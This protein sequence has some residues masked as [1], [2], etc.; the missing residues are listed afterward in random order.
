[1]LR[2]VGPRLIRGKGIEMAKTQKRG[3]Q[4]NERALD[5]LREKI[6][7]KLGF[8]DE[9][10]AIAKEIGVPFRTVERWALGETWPPQNKLL[11][12]LAYISK[13]QPPDW[14]QLT[15]RKDYPSSPMANDDGPPPMLPARHVLDPQ[16]VSKAMEEWQI[17]KKFLHEVHGIP[18]GQIDNALNGL[19]VERVSA[20]RIA[21]VLTGSI[22][23]TSLKLPHA[24]SEG[25]PKLPDNDCVIEVIFRNPVVPDDPTGSKTAALVLRNLEDQELA[26]QPELAD[27]KKRS[28]HVFIRVTEDEARRIKSAFDHGLLDYL[29]IADVKIL[30]PRRW[31]WQHLGGILGLLGLLCATAAT[32]LHILRPGTV[33]V[34]LLAVAGLTTAISGV[35]IARKRKLGWRVPAVAAIMNAAILV[36]AFAAFLPPRKDDN[37]GPGPIIEKDKG[38]D[39]GKDGKKGND[40][41]K[42]EAKDKGKDAPEKDKDKGGKDETVTL[43]MPGGKKLRRTNFGSS[44]FIFRG[45]IKIEGED[46]GTAMTVDCWDDP[47]TKTITIA[48]NNKKGTAQGFQ[49]YGA[50]LAKAVPISAKF[51]PAKKDGGWEPGIDLIGDHKP[52]IGGKEDDLRIIY[53]PHDDRANGGEWRLVYTYP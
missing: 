23:V 18:N 32:T 29:D 9:L 50:P 31:P 20:E 44:G 35:C 45:G 41:D 8:N 12:K 11:R 38:K 33:P 1:M 26:S 39:E 6:A 4:F 14:E 2:R 21:L 51:Y 22:D 19:P 5:D 43:P 24:H 53:D 17:T 28:V 42:N 34:F 52:K 40:R 48:V 46:G 36:W 25:S 27:V 15:K 49:L 7:R 16:L 10:Q 47:L 3:S 30:P 13:L 37:E